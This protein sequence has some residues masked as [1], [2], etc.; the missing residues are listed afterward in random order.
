MNFAIEDLSNIAYY[1]SEEINNGTRCFAIIGT[2]VQDIEELT[3]M[4]AENQRMEDP[5]D[6]GFSAYMD[7]REVTEGTNMDRYLLEEGEYI[8]IFS[9]VDENTAASFELAG[10][11]RIKWI[12]F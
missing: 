1:I 11:N 10:D 6:I 5:I 2:N 12:E 3:I 8:H 4:V 7:P 9:F